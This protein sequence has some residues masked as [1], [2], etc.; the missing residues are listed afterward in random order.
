MTLTEAIVRE[1]EPGTI[2]RS[3]IPLEAQSTL[4]FVPR[5]LALR[6]RKLIESFHS[7]HGYGCLPDLLWHSSARD[8]IECHRDLTSIFK[9]ASRS[10]S[11]KRANDSLLLIATIVF[12]VEMLARDFAGWGKRFPASKREAER[13]L[14]DVLQQ[15]H[16]WFMD[17]YLYPSL[18][19][20]RELTGELA[21]SP[22]E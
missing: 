3:D 20:H 8:V 1:I 10:R 9:A 2:G 5:E 4:R 15:P 18:A 16:A 19:I 13:L 14:G 17:M 6:A 7:I 21:P 22:A 12:S 11:A